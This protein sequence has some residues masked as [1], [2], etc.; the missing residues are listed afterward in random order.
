MEENTKCPVILTEVTYSCA[1]G[2]QSITNGIPTVDQI[3]E[4]TV[5]LVIQICTY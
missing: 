2:I 5:S 4:I 1:R 3:V